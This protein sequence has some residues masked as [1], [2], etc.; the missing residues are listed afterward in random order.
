M[1]PSQN[2]R[3]KKDKKHYHPHGLDPPPVGPKDQH[4]QKPIPT[5]SFKK[6]SIPRCF[7]STQLAAWKDNINQ[8]P[9]QQD[10]PLIKDQATPTIIRWKDLIKMKFNLHSIGQSTMRH[11][12]H[13]SLTDKKNS[14]KKGKTY[15]VY[16]CHNQY[17]RPPL[18]EID[19]TSYFWTQ[20][21]DQ[22]LVLS[23]SDFQIITEKWHA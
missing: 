8:Y 20:Q 7:N 5:A 2:N 6:P 16:P 10:K 23:L 17:V 12:S 15:E 11:K 19:Q 9:S 1:G 4:Q 22:P 14:I 18:V 13:D 3:G 21:W